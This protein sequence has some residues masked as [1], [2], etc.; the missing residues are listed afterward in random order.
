MHLEFSGEPEIN[1]PVKRVWTH[2]LDH[3]FVAHCAPGVKRVEPLSPSSFRVITGLAVGSLKLLFTLDVE[4]H[5]L[6][7]GESLSLTVRGKSAGSE[8]RARSAVAIAE[9]PRNRTRLTWTA[10]TTLMGTVVN[11]GSRLLKGSVRRI[12]QKFWKKF[13][14][15]V[16]RDAGRARTK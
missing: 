10:E 4:L 6:V 13:A 3:E 7:P 8:V 1:A 5:D 11:V 2:L 15:A 12:T 9:L 16:A 14:A